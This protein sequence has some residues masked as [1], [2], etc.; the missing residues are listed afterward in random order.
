M[1][2]LSVASGSSGNCIYVGNDE[3]RLLVDVGISKIRVETG[4]L[5]A[6][7][8]PDKIDGI[9]VTHEHSDHIGGLGVFLRKYAIPVYA[10]ALTIENILSTKSLGK[11]DPELFHPIR[12]DE[13]FDI[14]SIRIIPIKTS[15]DALDS[16]AYRFESDGK[17]LAVMT[18]LGEY[19]DY[20]INS[21]KELDAI[22][23]ES[24]HDVCMLE[25]GRYPYPLKQRI[26]GSKGHLSNEASAR[27]AEEILCERLKY[28]ILGHL[29]KENNMPV[30]AYET[31]KCEFSAS[32][33]DFDFNRI[34]VAKRDEVSE[35]IRV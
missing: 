2:L 24:N 22:L 6:G 18:D 14:G 21:L 28:I 4:L 25:C 16:L 19:D 12:A 33:I 35:L 32:G 10:T 17:A 5:S 34:M 29:S 13:P 31:Y 15:H 3:T 1:E 11:L 9:L 8:E 20:I 7:I 26:L 30:L 27:L 23:L